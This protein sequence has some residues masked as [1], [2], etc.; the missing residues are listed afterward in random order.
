MGIWRVYILALSWLQEVMWVLSKSYRGECFITVS[1]FLEHKRWG[2]IS[3]QSLLSRSTELRWS[4]TLSQ[5]FLW[6][7]VHSHRTVG[8]CFG[9]WTDVS[10][11]E[12]QLCS[13]QSIVRS[14]RK[15]ENLVSLFLPQIWLPVALCCIY[16][17]IIRAQFFSFLLLILLYFLLRCKI[18]HER[19]CAWVI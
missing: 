17:S 2:V 8:M 19:G 15:L 14:S 16:F 10:H 13:G 9:R 6:W 1:F 5:V 4:S 7:W 12:L 3:W 18:L 11:G